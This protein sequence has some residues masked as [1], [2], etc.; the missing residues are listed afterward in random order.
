MNE[1]FNVFIGYDPGE[2][3]AAEVCKYSLMRRATV[4]LNVSYLNL[5]ALRRAGLYAR[6]E[7]MDGNQRHDGIDRRPFS[8]DFSFSRFLVP[9]L[10]QFGQAGGSPWA[11]FCDS[12]MLWRKDIAPLLSA[13]CNR[14][15][16][17]MVVKHDYKP[18]DE[19]KM[20]GG[21]KQEKYSRKN[22]SSFMLFNTAHPACQMLIPAFV[23][24]ESGRWLHTFQWCRDKEIGELDS[25]WNWLEGHDS[26]ASDPA[27]VHFT[28]G[29]P[30]IPKYS[31]VSFAD[32]WLAQWSQL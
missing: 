1:A 26:P 19:Y 29:T 6:P 4:P 24:T 3:T 14:D 2:H 9:S 15:K 27:V 30:D 20:R 13:C 32:E 18:A 23:A 8:T 16:A 25:T 17:V 11:L 21:I 31:K 7:Y 10:M 5:Q 22:W 28:R 12:D